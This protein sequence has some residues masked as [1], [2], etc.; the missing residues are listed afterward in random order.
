[1]A[2]GEVEM[3]GF[4]K[5]W[6]QAYDLRSAAFDAIQEIDAVQIPLL[7]KPVKSPLQ[8][9][10]PAYGKDQLPFAQCAGDASHERPWQRR[11]ENRAQHVGN[12]L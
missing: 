1:M 12:R 3:V 2:A 8:A 5:F 10:I 6:Q 9:V 11:H 7:K 4:P